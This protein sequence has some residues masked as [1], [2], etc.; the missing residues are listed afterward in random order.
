MFEN[1]NR[2]DEGN[3]SKFLETEWLVKL[4]IVSNFV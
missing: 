2:V 3:F 4:G 1:E